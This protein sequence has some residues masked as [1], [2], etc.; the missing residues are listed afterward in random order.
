MKSQKYFLRRHLPEIM[1]AFGATLSAWAAMYFSR[2]TATVFL[3]TAVIAIATA[4][5]LVSFRIRERDF[6]FESL[7]SRAQQSDWVGYGTFEYSRMDRCFRITGSDSGFLFT[8][9]LSWSDYALTFRFKVLSSCLGVIVRAVNLS[10]LV[11]LQIGESGIRP[12]IRVNGVWMAWE[13]AA[14]GLTFRQSLDVNEWQEC[15]IKCDKD[16]IRIRI[17][18]G[19]T[20]LCDKAWKIPRGTLHFALQDAAPYSGAAYDGPKTIPFAINL[21]YGTVGFRN[22]GAEEALVRDVLLEKISL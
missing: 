10:N 14:A 5:V 11:M 12:H 13:A 16:T 6:Y 21:E 15:Q 4:F 2:D 19:R 20:V 22:D 18:Q 8:K 7:G 17:S 3:W 1:T 9:T